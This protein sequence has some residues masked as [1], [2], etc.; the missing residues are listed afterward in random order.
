MVVLAVAAPLS[1][2]PA[3]DEPPRV[4]LVLRDVTRVES[5]SYFAPAA[6]AGDPTYSFIGNRATLGVRATSTRIDVEGAF[7][8]A[9]LAGLPTRSFSTA[10][11]LGPGAMHFDAARG[12]RAYQLYFRQL[13]GRVKWS[14]GSI[15]IGR[16]NY[17]SGMEAESGE[18]RLESLKNDRLAARLIGTFDAS[19]FERAFDGGRVD[20]KR[21]RWLFTG[22]V[23][24]PTQGGYEESAN[25]TM[26]AVRIAT[27]VASVRPTR[28]IPGG[29]LQLF[30]YHYNDR[31]S[32]RARPDNSRLAARIVDASI[33]TFGAS[34]AGVYDTGTGAID[35]VLW[36]AAQA[37]DWYGEPHRALSLAIE[38][39]H[40]WRTRWTPRVRAGVT[41]ASGDDN[42]TD[43]RHHT[44]FQMVPSSRKYSLADVFAHMNVRDVFVSGDVEPTSRLRAAVQVHRVSLA[45]GQDRWY[46][47]S[48]PTSR[49]GVYFGFWTRP[50]GGATTLGTTVE[51]TASYQIT[52]RWSINGYL[53]GMRGGDV[54]RVLFA[55]TRLRSLVVE[56][57]VVF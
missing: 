37:G 53:G 15:S 20:V 18:A 25:P 36:V 47:G 41:Y 56:N 44:F 7:Q 32:V 33:G 12:S 28:I 51:A 34:H 57:V 27:A 8:Y 10:G 52:P 31:R 39:G 24:F 30:S 50:S 1:A 46:G 9:Q 2:Q 4:R 29:Q 23:M 13:W 14:A 42:P 21:G 3:S 5:W 17:T 55:G 45:T 16:M 43:G 26:S 48:G 35:T 54:V 49:L 19:M 40:Q 38:A 22:A 11:P 6:G